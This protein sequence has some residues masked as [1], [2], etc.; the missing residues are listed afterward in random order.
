MKKPELRKIFIA[1]RKELADKEIKAKS[2]AVAENFFDGFNLKKVNFLHCFI[3]IARFNEINTNLIFERIRRDFPHVR[4][5]APRIDLQTLE[6]KSLIYTAET[7]LAENSWKISEPAHDEFIEAEKIDIVLVPLLCADRR[8]FRVG[9]GKGFY[10]R[11]LKDCRADCL[12]IG[13]NYF[14]PV[15]EISDINEFDIKL[16][17]LVTPESVLRYKQ[18]KQ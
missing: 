9:Y 5:V 7:E 3:P 8:G 17:F 15:E 4:T 14:E 10:D 16:D 6:M 18:K 1:K 12:K 13:L 11:F 2:R